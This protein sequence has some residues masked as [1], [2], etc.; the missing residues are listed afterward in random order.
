MEKIKSLRTEDDVW[1]KFCFMAKLLKMS[2]GDLLKEMVEEKMQQQQQQISDSGII[3]VKPVEEEIYPDI[4]VTDFL[5]RY[6]KITVTTKNAA[7]HWAGE[8]IKYLRRRLPPE[9][10]NRLRELNT[11]LNMRVAAGELK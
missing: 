5:Q 3:K 9:Q 1:G 6:E 11:A 2:Q 10:K 7:V 8:M 4:E